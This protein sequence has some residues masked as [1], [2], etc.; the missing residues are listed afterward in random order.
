MSLFF[1]IK[2]TKI[3]INDIKNSL[4]QILKPLHAKKITSD[5]KKQKKILQDWHGLSC[6]KAIVR[7]CSSEQLLHAKKQSKN[8]QA[9]S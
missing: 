6:A 4:T 8:K 5:K 7:L 1:P 3:K 9:A 2:Q